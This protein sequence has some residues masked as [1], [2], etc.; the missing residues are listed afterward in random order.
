[1]KE[2]AWKK[3]LSDFFEDIEVITRCQQETLNDFDQ[4]CEFIAEPG[5][6]SLADELKKYKIKS[7]IKKTKNKNIAFQI[8]F[9]SS[10]IDNLTYIIYLPKNSI[11]L[12]L[13][14]RLKGRKSKNSLPEV[15]EELFMPQVKP[16]ELLK[17]PKEEII[18]DVI[19]H[20]KNFT[21]QTFT[22]LRK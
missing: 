22:D 2:P 17:L 21:Y 13:K 10:N 15:K 7:K 8:N 4:F 18:Q 6:E 20:Y 14:L 16:E 1:M 19:E 11:E 9:P 3:I 5:F 12:K